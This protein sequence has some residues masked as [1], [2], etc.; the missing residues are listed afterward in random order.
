MTLACDVLLRHTN[1]CREHLYR[2]HQLAPQCPRCCQQFESQEEL[3]AHSRLAVSCELQPC[4]E[5]EGITADVEKQL[6]SRK[7]KSPGQS[8]ADRWREIYQILF[9]GES[10][11]L[12]CKFISNLP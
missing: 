10:V 5:R 11:P 6:K 12:P 1:K 9:P 2:R 8:E 3:Q 4:G 7:K